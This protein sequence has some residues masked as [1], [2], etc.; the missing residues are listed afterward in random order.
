VDPLLAKLLPPDRP[1]RRRIALVVG[2]VAVL[3]VLVVAVAVSAVRADGGEVQITPVAV[4]RSAIP[5]PTPVLVQ[6]SGAVRR[7]GLVSVPSSARAVDAI[8]AAGGP[9]A[10][11]DES[12][13]NLAA[14]V[15]DGQHLVVPD[16]HATV[17]GPAPPTAGPG[18]PLSLGSA[19][20]AQ[21][22]TLP[23]IGPAMA[24]RIL[25]WREAH[26]GFRSVDDLLKV[27]G[28]GP[29]TFAGLKDLV[30]P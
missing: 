11:A 7:P 25:A 14:H 20:Q 9:T 27:G 30:T 17:G 29:K 21:L 10:A 13:V 26:G 4:A 16:R 6:V 15:V 23:R 3:A 2:G 5:S 8:A 12:Q 24:T 22:E 19:T 18:T 1:R 28:I